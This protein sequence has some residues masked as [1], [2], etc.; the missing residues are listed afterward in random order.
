MLLLAITN[1]REVAEEDIQRL[2][3]AFPEFNVSLRKVLNPNE[4][5]MMTSIRDVCQPH[6]DVSALIVI[7]MAHGIQGRVWS[8]DGK[9]VQ[10]Q[11]I[12]RQ[13]NGYVPDGRPKVVRSPL[14]F[15][16]SHFQPFRLLFC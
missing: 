11:D 8:G 13:M 10:I 3:N 7:I 15:L 12:L 14:R 16:G 1:E 4:D 6:G 2:D 9:E 5:E